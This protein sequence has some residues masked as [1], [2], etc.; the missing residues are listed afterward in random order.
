MDGNKSRT[1]SQEYLK[2]FR[3]HDLAQWYSVEATCWDCHRTAEIPHRR[4]KRGRPPQ[5]L[6]LT[7]E[8]KLRCTHCGRARG[9][10]ITVTKVPRNL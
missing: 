9:H 2:C 7:L 10:T 1:I 8:D 5:T 4:L 3:L 6:L